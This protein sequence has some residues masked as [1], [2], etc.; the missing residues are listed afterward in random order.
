MRT[1]SITYREIEPQDIP[2]LVAIDALSNNP[3]WNQKMFE[4]E[5]A[6]P[7][8]FNRVIQAGDRVI[9]FVIAR[10]MGGCT[11]IMELAVHP[12]FRRE[13]YGSQLL[14]YVIA[15]TADSDARRRRIELE[16]REDNL[17]AISFYKKNGF[18]IDGRRKGFYPD[19]DGLLMS[20]ELA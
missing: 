2:A 14:D 1:F 10:S 4:D 7:Y 20:C 18:R 6:F 15:K 5:L 19:C 17:T 16:V 11:E 13:S 3:P 8:S 9:A 12:D